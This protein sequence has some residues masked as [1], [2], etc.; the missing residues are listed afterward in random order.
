ME[1]GTPINKTR[2]GLRQINTIV[3]KELKTCP[4]ITHSV[5]ALLQSFPFIIFIRCLMMIY[6]MKSLEIARP[7]NPE[8][9]YFEEEE[10]Q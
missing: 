10:A 5:R 7:D 3:Y 6:L 9:A 2:S 1:S 8:K 4:D